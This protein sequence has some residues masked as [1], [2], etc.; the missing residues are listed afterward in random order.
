MLTEVYLLIFGVTFVVVGLATGL[1]WAVVETPEA[2][3][4]EE[5]DL[6]RQDKLSA[7]ATL[8]HVL[9]QLSYAKRLKL[10]LAE[11]NLDWSVGRLVLQ[12]LVAGVLVF[13]AL[14]HLAWIPWYGSL[15]VS[16]AVACIPLLHVRRLRSKRLRKVED[17]LPE[18][19]EFLA[20]ALVA[21]HS[22]PM[23]LELLGEEAEAPISTEV[24]KTVDEYNLGLSM[25]KSLSNMADRLPSVDI[26]FFVSAVNSQSRTGGNLHE[27]LDSLAETI[28]DRETLRGQVRAL[29]ANGRI[30]AII[31]TCLPFF[32]AAVMLMVN[33]QYLSILTNHPAGR[34]LILAGICGQAL[35]FFVINRIVD[36][37]V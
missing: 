1:A 25:E 6:L 33:S 8:A 34:L 32:I 35:A 17:Q 12:M 18:A 16:A 11:A 15:A 7:L 29:T 37:K 13:A 5:P 3:G 20:R 4:E 19:L 27:L 31:L 2:N 21:G 24:R 30:T 9:A 28:R 23:A 26:Q 14:L 36:I 22:L 10:L